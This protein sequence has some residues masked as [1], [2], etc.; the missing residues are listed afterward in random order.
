MMP[1]LYDNLKRIIALMVLIT[2]LNKIRTL[3]YI[4]KIIASD[5][6]TCIFKHINHHC[7]IL[8]DIDM[9]CTFKSAHTLA[10]THSNH[11]IT[12]IPR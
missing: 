1:L 6:S 9:Y 10:D 2:Q 5:F 11:V 4:Y 7:H 8:P 3:L 12:F